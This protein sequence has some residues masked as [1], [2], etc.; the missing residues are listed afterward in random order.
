MNLPV[1]SKRRFIPLFRRKPNRFIERLREHAFI[2]T[3][4]TQ[5]LV[6]YMA[7]P[8]MKHAARVRALERKADEIR[9]LLIDELN[10]TFV[11]PIDREDLFA[12]SRAIDDVLDH[13]YSTTHEMDVLRV[14]PNEH[15]SSLAALL[16]DSAEEIYLAIEQLEK[17][18]RAADAHAVR[19]KAIENR[20]EE[21]YAQA[22]A[23]LFSEPQDMN[24]VIQMFKLR[25]IYRHM[26]HAVGSAERAADVIGDIVIKSF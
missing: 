7:A 24:D 2:V 13:A 25:E 12:L 3:Q 5:A 18:P 11:T 22:L 15:L 8:G 16:H 6:D 9:R 4:G 23:Q 1:S 20:A 21:L 19:V 26:F 14:R 10:R 17:Q